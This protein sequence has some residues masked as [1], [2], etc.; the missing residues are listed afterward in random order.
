MAGTE[1]QGCD[2]SRG[3]QVVHSVLSLSRSAACLNRLIT[4]S[5][6]HVPCLYI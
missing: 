5:L 6:G 2:V 4:A 3:K 1:I